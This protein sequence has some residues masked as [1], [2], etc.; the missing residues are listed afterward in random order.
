[1]FKPKIGGCEEAQ[2]EEQIG[3][4]KRERAVVHYY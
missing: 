2:K 4:P 1:M 3:V